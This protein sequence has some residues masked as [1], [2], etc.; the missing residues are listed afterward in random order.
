MEVRYK[1]VENFVHPTQ[2][3]LWRASFEVDNVV[4]KVRMCCEECVC[5]CGVQV[6][7][8]DTNVFCKVLF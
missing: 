1:D 3:Q 2:R 5:K 4:G 7:T 6:N 8:V